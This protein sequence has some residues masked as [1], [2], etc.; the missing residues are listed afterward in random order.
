MAKHTIVSIPGDGIGPEV[1]KATQRVVEAAGMSVAWVELP[2]RVVAREQGDRNRRRQRM[3]PAISAHKLALK[4]P[5]PPP[6][7]K[8][9]SSVNVQP[10][11]RLNLYAAVRP[12]KSIPGL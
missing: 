4:G 1:M 2:A 9:F 7:G 12:V 6:V 5:I 10:R 11:K 3:L 8:G